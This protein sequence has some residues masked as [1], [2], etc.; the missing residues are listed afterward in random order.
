MKQFAFIILFSFWI[1]TPIYG[2]KLRPEIK[3]DVNIIARTIK[4][5][6]TCIGCLSGKSKAQKSVSSLWENAN[7]EELVVLTDHRN[8]AIRCYSFHILSSRNY[9]NLFPILVKYLRDSITIHT[10]YGCLGN[11]ER[12]GD[13]ALSLVS[14]EAVFEN[15]YH[16]S[17]IEKYKIDSILLYGKD[18]FL[19]AK[20]E[21]LRK[22][23]PDTEY[24]SRIR[25]IVIEENNHVA[26][27]ALSK[28]QN[29]QDVQLIKDR[30]SSS[31]EDIQ[32]YGLIA[33]KNFPD[34]AFF[35]LIKKI[36]FTEVNGKGRSEFYLVRN[37]YQAIVVYKTKQA[38]ALLD[39]T[40]DSTS[41]SVSSYHSRLIWLAIHIYY[42][43]MYSD[44]Y[45]KIALTDMKRQELE[46]WMHK[47]DR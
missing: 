23:I 43:T 12:V 27:I 6:E 37:L 42:D 25:E 28:Y 32:N 10:L 26:L 40:I 19:E 45:E 35:P 8:T 18:I 29:Q 44:I 9:K 34:T 20:D 13:Y 36:H 15:Y 30:L 31:S 14:Q 2:Q 46:H 1:Q 5:N 7:N 16:L 33:V 47:T 11:D 24:Y 21:L 3:K 39:Y 22:L 17:K 4:N 38:R 41:Q